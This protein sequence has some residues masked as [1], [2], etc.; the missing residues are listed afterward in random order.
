MDFYQSIWGLACTTLVLGLKTS[1]LENLDHSSFLMDEELYYQ[2]GMH[3]SYPSCRSH[4]TRTEVVD[5]AM[6]SK[7]SS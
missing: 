1:G 5:P 6:N 4:S 2:E 7:D 3:G